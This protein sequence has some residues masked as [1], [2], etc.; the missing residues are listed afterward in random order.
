MTLKSEKFTQLV[1]WAARR[2]NHEVA[3]Y[4]IRALEAFKA[5]I[6]VVLEISEI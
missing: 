6:P 3:Q 2:E 5:F 1:G 4:Q